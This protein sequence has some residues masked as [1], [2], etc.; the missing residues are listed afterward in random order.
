MTKRGNRQSKQPVT[1]AL[2]CEEAAR[3]DARSCAEVIVVIIIISI[4]II[5]I[6]LLNQ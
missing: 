2:G 5:R 6:I 3:N 4:N 1:A